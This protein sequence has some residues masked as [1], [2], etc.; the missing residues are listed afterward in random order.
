L[1]NTKGAVFRLS[2]LIVEEFLSQGGIRRCTFSFPFDSV[3][4]SMITFLFF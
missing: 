2:V 1:P 3:F 4:S